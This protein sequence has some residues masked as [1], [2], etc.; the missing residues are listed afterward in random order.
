LGFLKV[1]NKI[2][3]KTPF[4]FHLENSFEMRSLGPS[5]SYQVSL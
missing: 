3:F 1:H 2:S 5:N 4:P